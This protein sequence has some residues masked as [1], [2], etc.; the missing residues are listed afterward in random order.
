M[1]SMVLVLKKGATKK[2]IESIN[3]KLVRSQKR[4]LFDAKKHCGVIEIKEDALSI[5]KRMRDEWS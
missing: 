1:I 2:E 4:K 3:Q 5:Q